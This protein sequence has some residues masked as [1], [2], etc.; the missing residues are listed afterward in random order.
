MEFE[1]ARN[2]IGK[3]F[4]CQIIEIVIGLLGI[5]IA[6]L[7]GLF[8]G[9]ATAVEAGADEATVAAVGTG[10]G[11]LF[12]VIAL[13]VLTIVATVL[14][15][16]GLSLA[17]KDE[18]KYFGGALGLAVLVLVAQILR[19]LGSTVP[20]LAQFDN[21]LAGLVP[22]STVLLLI[23]TVLGIKTI[24]EKLGRKDIVSMSMPIIIIE[25]IVY[26]S[27]AVTGLSDGIMGIVAAML[28]FVGYIIYF[29][30]LAKA[31]AMFR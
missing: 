21:Y 19:G 8:V 29:V 14:Q 18:P 10:I 11:A 13:I 24:A 28:A 1:N 27:S 5:L 9:S 30:Y 20:F 2:G 7:A 15:I 4:T 31:K 22:L 26:A 25:S 12:A 16:K 3:L 17:R 6:V 23:M